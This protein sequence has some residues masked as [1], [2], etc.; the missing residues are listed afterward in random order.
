M[1]FFPPVPEHDNQICPFEQAKML[2][3][4]LAAHG[5]MLAQFAQRLTIGFMQLIEQFS[6]I[7]IGQGLK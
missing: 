7:R 5:Q 3:H 1:K 2:A 4:S 6:A